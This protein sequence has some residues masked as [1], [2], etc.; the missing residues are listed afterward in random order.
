MGG[1]GGGGG[2]SSTSGSG[3][4]GGTKASGGSGGTGGTG[5]TGGSGG[6][7][8]TSGAGGTGGLG[9]TSTIPDAAPPLPSR[10]PTPATTGHNFPFPQNREN[11]RCVYPKLYNNDDVKAAYAKWKNDTVTSDGANGFRRV[12]RPNEPGLEPNSTVS[13]GIGYGMILAVF[14]DDQALFDDL[15]K[16]EQAHLDSQT[17]LMNWYIKADGSDIG[18]NPSGAGPASDADEDM[19]FAQVMADKQ[20]GGK[21]SSTRTYVDWA[22][23]TI[24]KIWNKEVISGK[25]L[26]PWPAT[27]LPAINL[28]Y[29]APAYYK[30]F[31]KVDTADASGWKAVTDAM[32][33]VLAKSLNASSGNSSN[34]LVP[35]WCDGNGVPNAG[36][37]GATGGTAPTNYQYDSCRTP[38][39]IGLDYCWT[40]ETRAK[41]Y[42]SKTSSFFNDT[43]GGAIKIVDGYALNGSAQAQY[44][45]GAKAQIQSAAFV[46]PAG[47]GAMSSPTY[48]TFVN[49]AYG[50]LI[51]G[52]AIVGGTYYDESWMVLSLLMMTANYLDF[53]AI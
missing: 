24:G 18:S 42:V 23:E 12:K 47:V 30:I 49:D 34:G 21:G 2:T 15:W 40:G 22:K 3:G 13:E 16:Y 44:Q 27:G 1:A 8:G 33:D 32:Y 45:T 7:G 50:V 19:A 35:A 36:A 41:D 9:G 38:F 28:S 6:A 46:G 39:R 11:S 14:M 31:A 10:G 25:Y 26:S 53:T 20:W 52:D 48:Q 51:T 4:S 43:V 29:F 17:Y 37:F 5:G